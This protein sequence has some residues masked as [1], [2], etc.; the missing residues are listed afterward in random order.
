MKPRISL[1]QGRWV[2]R[3]LSPTERWPQICI[4]HVETFREAIPWLHEVCEKIR[5]I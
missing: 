3:Y 5:A 2:M 1:E 4:V